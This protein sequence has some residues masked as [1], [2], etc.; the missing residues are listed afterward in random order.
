[1]ARVLREV[2][3]STGVGL[4]RVPAAERGGV[5][6]GYTRLRFGVHGSPK[7]VDEV[8]GEVEKAGGRVSKP[9]TVPEEFEGRHAYFADP[10]LN[11]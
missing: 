10:E 5:H 9:P 4:R 2:I 1:V 8:I 6:L 7:Q 3:G 11:Y